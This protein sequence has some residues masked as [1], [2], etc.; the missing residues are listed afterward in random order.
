MSS[1]KEYLDFVLD[2]AP[3]LT[4]R[5]MMGEYLLYYDKKLVGG[6][7]DDRLLVKNIPA[8]RDYLKNP[9]LETPYD[10]AKPMILIE[11]VENRE[12]LKVLFDILK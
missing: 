4:F 1:H 8:A 10:G 5:K 6:V 11:D 7:Y 2:N 9:A 3:Y 12:M